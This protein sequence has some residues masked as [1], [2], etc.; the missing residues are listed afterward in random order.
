[1]EQPKATDKK[2]PELRRVLD[3]LSCYLSELRESIRNADSEIDEA[4]DYFEDVETH[5]GKML[6]ENAQF[7]RKKNDNDAKIADALLTVKRLQ[8]ALDAALNDVAI[9]RGA[10]FWLGWT[11]L[12]AVVVAVAF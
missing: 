1:M 11:V 12:A 8:N 4:F 7:A 5:V 2:K 9:Y 6:E 10:A 3:G